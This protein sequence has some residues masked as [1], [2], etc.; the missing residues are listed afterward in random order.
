MSTTN[1]N[2][3]HLIELGYTALEADIYLLLL[4]K[5]PLTGYRIASDLGKAAANTYKAL[6]SLE[7]KGA[8]TL[9]DSQ[10][11]LYR[12]VPVEEFL[13]Q[14]DRRYTDRR[15]RAEEAL[16]G[17][18]LVERDDRIYRLRSRD[19]IAERCRSILERAEF[20]VLIDGD[21]GF[22]E[23][24]VPDIEGAVDRGVQ[25]AIKAYRTLAIDGARIVER[26]RPE[27]ITAAIP[28]DFIVLNADGKEYLLARVSDDGEVHHAIWTQAAT[29]AFQGYMGLIN[30]LS[31]TSI[32]NLLSMDTSI[33]E[34]RETFERDR[35]LHPV[36]SRNPVL[37]G[38][39][40][41]LGYPADVLPVESSSPQ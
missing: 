13:R 6:E 2:S 27:E 16:S 24:M 21:A 32:M 23:E 30:E 19:Q 5:S 25:V 8:V 35:P 12:P 18:G 34:L 29:I 36:S 31:L 9:D 28:G 3:Q 39:L 4:H 38:L 7:A 11:R 40:E 14:L 41:G 20:A 37:I 22:L 10:N 1:T 26:I 33:E 17:F 15:K